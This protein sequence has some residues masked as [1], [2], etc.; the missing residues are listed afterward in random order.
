MD[1][2]GERWQRAGQIIH[3][4]ASLDPARPYAPQP[5]LLLARLLARLLGVLAGGDTF[6]CGVFAAVRQTAPDPQ[7]ALLF[8]LLVALLLAQLTTV[9]RRPR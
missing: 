9:L 4:P 8:A 1:G 7:L 2:P 5:A 3:P 6:V